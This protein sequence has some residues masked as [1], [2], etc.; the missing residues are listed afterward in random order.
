[1]ADRGILYVAAKQDRYVEEAL[2]SADS[3]KRRH[4]DLSITLFTTLPSHPLCGLGCF[5]R[6]EAIDG[7][8][9][10]NSRWAEGQLDRLRC[11]VRSPYELTLHLD[12]D[13]RV[14]TDN[15]APLFDL[16]DD[17][18][19]AMAE[20]ALDDS[21]SRQHFGRRMFNGGLVL[22][23]RNAKTAEWLAAWTA[24]AER[25]FA[26]ASTA[27]LPQPTSVDHVASE[28]VRRNLLFNDQVA[29]VE[30]LSPEIN[31]FDLAFAALDY[32]WNHRGSRLPENNRYPVRISH[33][34]ALRQLTHADLLATAFAWQRDGRSG[35]A[36][37][38]KAYVFGKYPGSR[39]APGVTP[40]RAPS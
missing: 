38:L 30:I 10:F 23:R 7:A 9:G 37:R 29:L 2:L 25:N 11:L 22:S 20:T 1:M 40:A 12:A 19:V 5:D 3:V 15:L 26:Q 27:P 24:L 6:I 18:D 31:R 36:E 14:V 33:A 21:Y 17:H 39:D 34:P 35:E 13:T 4:P 32:S 8:G 16:L 28:Q